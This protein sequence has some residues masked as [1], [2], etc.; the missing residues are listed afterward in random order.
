M[1]RPY[2]GPRLCTRCKVAHTWSL[3]GV[4]TRCSG[5]CVCGNP[6]IAGRD[7]CV[8][9]AIGHDDDTGYSYRAQ[10]EDYRAT[11]QAL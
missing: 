9:C 3:W 7:K 4:C 1:V 2:R 10:L 5:Y 6:V 11:G 8:Q